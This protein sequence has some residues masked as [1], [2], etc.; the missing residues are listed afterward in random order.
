[1]VP[2]K[3]FFY[4]TKTKLCKNDVNIIAEKD[5]SIELWHKRLRHMN[6]KG[7]HFLAHKNFVPEFKGMTLRPCVDYLAGKQH[8]LLFVDPLF[9]IVLRIF[10]ILCILI[11][12]L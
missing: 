11:F 6:E 5:S 4:V 3:G 8:R 7:L 12:V 2:S 1:M 10:L 9:H